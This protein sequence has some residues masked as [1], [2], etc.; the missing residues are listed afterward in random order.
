[1]H[2]CTV[3]YMFNR[4]VRNRTLLT[5]FIICALIAQIILT[6]SVRA[7]SLDL[8]VRVVGTFDGR[9]S[10]DYTAGTISS[11]SESLSDIY[12]FEASCLDVTTCGAAP[13]ADWYFG[14]GTTFEDAA[15]KITHRY[16]NP[17]KFRVRVVVKSNSGTGSATHVALASQ[18]FA[19]V[20]LD[21]D[22]A[23]VARSDRFSLW[24]ASALGF[25]KSCGPALPANIINLSPTSYKV[26]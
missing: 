18:K 15:L 7:S 25:I 16:S 12:T 8:E 1:M 17:G 19:D 22:S 26:N 13:T 11:T 10:S 2:T 6:S 3:F 23:E 20:H 4:L 9:S 14:D 5:L 24:A 21:I